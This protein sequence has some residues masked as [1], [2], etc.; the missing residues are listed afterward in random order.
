L[1]LQFCASAPAFSFTSAHKSSHF[2][3]HLKMGV[4]D[5]LLGRTL[6][7]VAH[8]DDES[9]GC[10]ALLQRM[11]EPIVVIAT[12]GAPRDEF[13]WAQSGSRLR[14]ARLRAEEA[15]T[16]LALAGVNEVVWLPDASGGQECFVDQELYRA[17]REA[18]EQLAAVIRRYRPAALLTSAYE[19]GH[20]DHDVC[21]FLA[22]VLGRR[23]QLPVW[24]FPLYHR[25]QADR[26]IFQRFLFPAG[27][28]TEVAATPAELEIK[29]Q[30]L[31]AYASQ[32]PFLLEFDPS[33]ER[34]RQQAICDYSQPPHSGL[35]N[36]EAWQWPIKG[37]ELCAEF[38][39]FLDVQ[40]RRAV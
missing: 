27:P 14:Y 2:S 4:P 15:H 29:R 34:F 23:H 24:E 1:L 22:A 17:I 31:V 16:A 11:A 20:P 5:L 13:F 21:S 9:V 30:M 18:V 6:V 36:Y 8:A 32:H 35:L 33:R 37:S 10:G 38:M 25:M 40:Q 28:E 19:G 26:P 12:D 39:W 3:I 7:L